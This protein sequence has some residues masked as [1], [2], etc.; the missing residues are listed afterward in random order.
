MPVLDLNDILSQTSPDNTTG[1]TW[2]EDSDNPGFP[3]AQFNA[4]AGEFSTAGVAIGTY[5][6]IYSITQGSLPHTAVITV[7]LPSF[8]QTGIG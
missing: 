8:C 1:G 3:N 5:K 4:A 6:F 2:T 7:V